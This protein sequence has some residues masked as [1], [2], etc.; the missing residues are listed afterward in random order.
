MKLRDY[1]SA[2]I[3]AVESGWAHAQRQ[4]G[5]AA[6]GAGK[7]IMFSCLAE[8]QAGRT[9]ILAHREE[10]I[11]QAVEKLH[12][13]TGIHASVE[14]AEMR[15]MPGHGVIVAS[16]QSMRRR[17]GKYPADSFDLIICD[18][19]HHVLADEWLT[20]LRHFSACQRVL[21]VT[22]T[23]DRADRQN[24]GKY[25]QRV[26]FEISLFDLIS[27]RYLAPLEFRRLPVSVD[28]KIKKRRRDFSADEA[29]EAINPVIEALADAVAEEIWD[30]KALIFL[31]LC[32][33]S[34][35]FSILL[36]ERG[37]SAR[38]V[39]GNSTARQEILEWFAT[40]GPKA[41]TN[42]MLLTEGFDQPDVDCVVCL[43][44]TK[45]RALYA[46]I[47]GRG[48]RLWP[49]KERCLVLDPLWMANEHRLVKPCMLSNGDEEHQ[50]RV[51]ENLDLG[52]DLL[53]AE[54]KA[55][56]DG[57]EIIL[58]R[59]EAVKMMEAA[60][61]RRRAAHAAGLVDHHG[62]EI[63]LNDQ[64]LIDFEPTEYWETRPVGGQTQ[65]LLQTFGLW[66]EGML[67]G[68]AARLMELVEK[69]RALRLASPKQLLL[70]KKMGVPD[71]HLLSL[72][73]ARIIISAKI[74]R[75]VA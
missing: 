31:P 53:E 40:P 70:L 18:E 68:R 49:G 30:R 57:A 65:A 41:L 34:L 59:L 37:I 45:S 29:G 24:L 35:R 3:E 55:K 51:Q 32:D 42:A 46:Q 33:V 54:E 6:T 64:T 21:G 38:H 66:T 43:R 62:Y 26:A 47:I 7:T 61:A 9:L 16:V 69:R 20:V 72:N 25:F 58:K 27:H 22:A 44:P 8:R 60:A 39:D 28:M 2:A 52:M 14:R 67:A 74:G 12:A 13:A 56:V 75:R 4:L 73:D 63:A 10:L 36:E 23:P 15:A 5:V 19:A 71:A 50:Q 1:Q 17:L 11:N 48:T